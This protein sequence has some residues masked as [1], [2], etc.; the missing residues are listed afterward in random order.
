MINGKALVAYV[1]RRTGCIHPFRLSR[2]LALI[3]VEWLRDRG[4][5]LTDIKY[6]RGL[7]TFYIEELKE[8]VEGDPCFN[9]REG[10]P[11]TR[12]KG[13]IEYRC[14][15]PS[16]PDDVRTFID[17]ILEKTLSLKDQELN[18]AVVNNELFE[19]I[20]TLG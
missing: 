14:E 11:K 1:L 10:D 12:R 20:S 7:G 18:E 8:S 17:K 19:R 13:C 15:P 6:V 4:E 16:L 5:R 2:I 9:K 3:E